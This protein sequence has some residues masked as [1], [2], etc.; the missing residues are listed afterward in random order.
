[1]KAD[2]LPNFE[3][4]SIEPW[5]Y[6]KD[7]ACLAKRRLEIKQEAKQG[8]LKAKLI[9]IITETI[10][11][12]LLK[13]FDDPEATTEKQSPCLWD[14]MPLEIVLHIFSLGR[15]YIRQQCSEETWNNFQEYRSYARDMGA[16]F[17]PVSSK[18]RM[19]IN[20]A[21]ETL[22]RECTSPGVTIFRTA[23]G[24]TGVW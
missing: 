9:L 24:T 3:E 15:R 21:V 10:L 17:I 22:A 11:D 6:E 7:I 19:N 18:H 2:L 12:K 23:M 5:T 1:M 13:H 8:C 20:L 16:K 14:L 4:I